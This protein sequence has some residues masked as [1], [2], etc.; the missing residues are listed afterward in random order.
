MGKGSMSKGKFGVTL[1]ELNGS[2][3]EVHDVPQQDNDEYNT[4]KLVKVFKSRDECFAAWEQ[5][6]GGSEDSSSATI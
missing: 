5:R 6:F 4:A 2:Y 3:V 1:S